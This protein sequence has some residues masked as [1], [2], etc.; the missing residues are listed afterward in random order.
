MQGGPDPPRGALGVQRGG[1]GLGVGVELEDRAQLGPPRI[2]RLD[3]LRVLPH[4]VQGGGARE[5]R[6]GR[7]DEVGVRDLGGAGG[8]ERGHGGGRGRRREERATGG[9]GGSVARNDGLAA[10]P[11]LLAVLAVVV[12][13]PLELHHRVA[14]GDLG[15]DQRAQRLDVGGALVEEAVPDEGH[16]GDVTCHGTHR[17]Y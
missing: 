15:G 5:A 13:A 16:Q 10:P 9:H 2:R 1:D 17:W 11:V 6:E 12:L 3:P 7:L 14:A 4:Q 8:S